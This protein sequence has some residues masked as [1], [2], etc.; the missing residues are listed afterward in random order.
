MKDYFCLFIVFYIFLHSFHTVKAQDFQLSDEAEISILTGSP[1]NELYAA[2]G[3]TA[4]HIKDTA[5]GIDV[6]FNYGIFD[7][8]TPNFYMKFVQGK[9][10]YQ[11]AITDYEGLIALYKEGNRTLTEQYLLLDKKQKQEVF[12]FL[13]D[14]SKPENSAYKYDFF[15]DN[16][17][18]R[19]R[20]V[21][22]KVL[23]DKLKWDLSKFPPDKSFRDLINPYLVKMPW[24]DMGM[25]LILGMPTDRKANLQEY[26]FLPDYIH[27]GLI[28]TK[29]NIDGRLRPFV[30]K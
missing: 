18:T 5:N 22:N 17:A 1:G 28:N 29:I 8:E 3:H 16:C 26:M 10:L 2:F 30:I 6:L 15:F 23:G 27:H 20:D 21:L 11:L 4:I 14:N 19:V 7:F 12:D 9:L 13:V 24:V 25:D